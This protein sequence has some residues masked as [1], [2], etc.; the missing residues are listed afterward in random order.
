MSYQAVIRD[1]ANKLVVN[2]SIGMRV[3][4]IVQWGPTPRVLYQETYSP[5]PQTN[6][7]GLVS[8][9][10]GSGIPVTG[11]FSSINWTLGAYSIQ[12]ETDPTGGT[13]YTITGTSPLLSVPFALN[14]NKADSVNY[15]NIIGAPTFSAVATS[16]SY[17]DLNNRPTSDGSET[18]VTAGTNIDVTGTG[19]TLSPYVVN[20]NGFTHYVGELYGGGII[21]AVWKQANA[22]HGLIASLTDLGSG[23]SWSNVTT[24]LIGYIAESP[25]NGQANSN[26]IIAQS[27]QTSIAAQLCADYTNTNTGTGVYSDWYLP[28]VWELNQCYN[29]AFVITTIL[30]AMNGIGFSSYWS[31]T[32][33]DVGYAWNQDFT[34]GKTSPR[35]KGD[36]VGVRAVRAF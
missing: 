33:Q 9:A 6:A 16:G 23:S 10:I 15:S 20:A 1:A 31:S 32:E 24:T 22:E 27:G 28:A 26:A 29:S 35:G 21:V 36:H 14:A 19:T 34:S 2:Q 13:N 8:I 12:T 5:N 7:N 4:I 30:G 11:T 25:I 17:T 3:S 18:K